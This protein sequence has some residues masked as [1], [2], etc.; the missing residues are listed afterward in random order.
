MNYSTVYFIKYFTAWQYCTFGHGFSK[1]QRL[2]PGESYHSNPGIS[3]SS[4]KSWHISEP[5]I[6]LAP[7]HPSFFSHKVAQDGGNASS[8]LTICI[9]V[10]IADVFLYRQV[11]ISI[12]QTEARRSCGRMTNINNGSRVSWDAI[13]TSKQYAPGIFIFRQ[14]ILY[15]DIIRCCFGVTQNTNYKSQW[16]VQCLFCGGLKIF[17]VAF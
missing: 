2:Y 3:S 7:M 17:N 15:F 13:V 16:T 8:L 10:D 5:R 4:S 14:Y 1:D 12:G 9:F 6:S 11:S